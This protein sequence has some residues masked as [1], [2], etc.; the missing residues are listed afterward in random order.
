MAD[1][2]LNNGWE[3][4]K[5]ALDLNDPALLMFRP[6]DLPHD[7]LIYDTE[8]L[9]EDSIGWYR[10]YLDIPS[11]AH[12]FL[13]FEGVYM[14][15]SLYVNGEWI[16]EWKNGYTSFEF[17][18]TQALRPGRNEILVKV[19]HQAPNSRWYTGAG[20]Y[21][22]VW[23]KTRQ[24]NYLVTDGVYISTRLS[25]QDLH[26]WVLEIETEVALG[27]AS[28]VQLTHALYYG[29]DILARSSQ[30]WD[31]RDGLSGTINDLRWKV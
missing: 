28:P 17:E 2:L 24:R 25:G 26:S 21:R 18:I 19:V 1:I 13:Y 20:I 10:R 15:C 4:A 31:P 12:V 3:F 9:Y 11:S 30:T 16:G 6:V 23:L 8:N 7:W 29:G 5:S 27:S 22:D 14:D